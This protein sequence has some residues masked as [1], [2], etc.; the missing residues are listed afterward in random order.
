MGNLP[1]SV[2]EDSL[3]D[4]FGEK[5]SIMAIRLPTDVES[6]RPKGFGYVQ[7]GS[8]D[9]ARTAFNDLHGEEING[10]PMRLDFSLPKPNNGGGGGRGGRGGRGGGRGGRG[11][12]GGR[13]GGAAASKN[14]GSITEYKGTKMT[15]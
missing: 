8:V 7:Y 9:E 1:F 10:R 11:G 2:S 12:F 14:R 6:G 5:G 3:R 13:G 4:F 15:F